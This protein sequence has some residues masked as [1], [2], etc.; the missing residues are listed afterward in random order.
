M[1]CAIGGALGGAAGAVGTAGYAAW[2]EA[3]EY[4]AAYPLLSRMTNVGRPIAKHRKP[5]QSGGTW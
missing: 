4:N 5:R 1:G 3:N 2:V